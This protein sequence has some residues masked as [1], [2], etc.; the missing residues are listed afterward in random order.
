[1]GRRGARTRALTS[2]PDKPVNTARQQLGHAGEERVIAH[3]QALGF[4]LLD[5]NWHDGRR[6]EIDLVFGLDQLIVICEVK[7]RRTDTYGD[8]LEAVTADKQ[9]RLRRL[10]AAWIAA[11]R[12]IVEHHW[13]H[14]QIDLRIDVAAV[15]LGVG[16]AV[17][18]VVEGAC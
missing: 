1:V 13:P 5:R 2:K 15:R 16:P 14:G 3:Y 9:R 18:N 17:I 10:A 4:V 8:G 6:G 7:T 12:D 11:K